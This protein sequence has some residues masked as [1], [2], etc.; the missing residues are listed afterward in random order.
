M[1]ADVFILAFLGL[2]SF[3]V[4][5]AIAAYQTKTLTR[6]QMARAGI[7]KGMPY[8]WH[9]GMWSDVYSIHPYL[10][11]MTAVLWWRWSAYPKPL[12]VFLFLISLGL[13]RIAQRSWSSNK[14]IIESHNGIE[15]HP[16]GEPTAT[17]NPSLVGWVHVPHIAAIITLFVMTL[18]SWILGDLPWR[19]VIAG[20]FMLAGH[21]LAG[22]H[23]LLRSLNP[24]WNPWPADKH[25]EMKGALN[26]VCTTMGYFFILCNFLAT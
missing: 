16:G 21:G 22:T 17:G 13:G 19:L 15:F 12:W 18:V 20:L 1:L 14:D 10:A 3:W 8:L 5:G 26:V 6:A 25:A 4:A 24:V 23:W 2:Q 11:L 7:K 9:V